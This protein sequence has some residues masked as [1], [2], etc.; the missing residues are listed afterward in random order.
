MASEVSR[1]EF[2]MT[3]KG[4][5]VVIAKEQFTDDGESKFLTFQVRHGVRTV[6]DYKTFKAASAVAEALV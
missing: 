6:G 3:D 4:A 5:V 2:G 1:H